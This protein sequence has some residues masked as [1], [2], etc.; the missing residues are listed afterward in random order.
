L[1][2]HLFHRWRHAALGGADKHGA[3]KYP[4]RAVIVATG[5]D[6]G[7]TLPGTALGTFSI[8]PLIVD[9]VK[10]CFPASG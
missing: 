4:L 2:D 9:A 8:V 10:R 3:G 6:E 5:F 7:G 1:H